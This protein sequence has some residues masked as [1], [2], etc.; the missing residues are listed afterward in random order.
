VPQKEV[1]FFEITESG[2]E[3]SQGCDQ[4]SAG[5]FEEVHGSRLAQSSRAFSTAFRPVNGSSK[6][7]KVTADEFVQRTAR[8]A[9]LHIECS[10]VQEAPEAG[11]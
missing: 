6:W 5:Y 7:L 9:R 11:W 2:K 8:E 3:G 10:R 4:D 1:F